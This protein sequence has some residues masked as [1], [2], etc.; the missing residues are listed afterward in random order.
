MQHLQQAFLFAVRARGA[1]TL[2]EKDAHLEDL[3]K[4]L[5]TAMRDEE[6]VEAIRAPAVFQGG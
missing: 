1:K 6:A 3:I 2:E 5:K 4:V